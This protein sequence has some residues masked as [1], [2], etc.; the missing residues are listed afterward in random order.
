MVFGGGGGV[1][2]GPRAATPPA[3]R[4]DFAIAIYPGLLP[5]AIAVPKKAP[6]LF[7]AAAKDD[8]LA[9]A[10]S[11]R[12]AAAWKG[13][14]ASSTIVTYESGGHGFGM[15]KSGKPSD[16]WTGAMATWMRGQGLVGK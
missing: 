8:K 6:P 1:R 13:A 2:V 15:K 10:D 9:Y 12:L 16:A 5:D 14:G 4:P 7:V 3:P 11:V